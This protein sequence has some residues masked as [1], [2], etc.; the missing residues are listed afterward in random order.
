MLP[1]GV[2]FSLCLAVG[3]TGVHWWVEGSSLG[4]Q[5]QARAQKVPTKNEVD[6]VA[7]DDKAA[8]F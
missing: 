1:L 3:G 6:G 8:G 7:G 2:L 4:L 5:A